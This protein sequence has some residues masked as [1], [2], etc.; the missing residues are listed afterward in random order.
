MLLGLFEQRLDDKNRVTI[1]AKLRERFEDGVVLTRGFDGCLQL[2]DV[3]AWETFC[4]QQLYRADVMD[5]EGRQLRRMF[6]NFALRGELDA[7]GRIGI[8][9]HLMELA[10]LDRDVFVAGSGD[11]LE[12]WDREAYRRYMAKMEGRV[13]SVAER[14]A[15]ESSR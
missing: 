11:K 15:S 3:S 2:F 1:P 4:T 8:P 14:V 6:E 13:E 7:Q 12:I 9:A 5:G 10:A